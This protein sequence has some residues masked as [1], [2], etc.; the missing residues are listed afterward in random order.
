[1]RKNAIKESLKEKE[2]PASKLTALFQKAAND[3]D[4][5]NDSD[6]LAQGC[7]FPDSSAGMR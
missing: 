2:T 7:V 3:D 1:M 4:P 6:L 5:D